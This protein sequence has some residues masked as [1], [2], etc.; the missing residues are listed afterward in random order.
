MLFMLFLTSE[1][2]YQLMKK[3]VQRGGFQGLEVGYQEIKICH[4][5]FADDILV[6]CTA[7]SQYI[8]NL[9]RILECFQVLSGLRINFSKFGL[10]VLGKYRAWGEQIAQRLGCQVVDLPIVYLA[11]P[12][13]AD[14][15][16]IST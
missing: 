4:L 1:A 16:K 3:A 2:F 7:R 13:G 9:R 15:K 10:I 6:F 11:I 14:P 5:Q 8:V 12:L